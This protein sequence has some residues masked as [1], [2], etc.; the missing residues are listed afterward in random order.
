MKIPDYMNK[1]LSVAT[2]IELQALDAADKRMVKLEQNRM[3]IEW[4]GLQARRVA[5]IDDLEARLAMRSAMDATI[6]DATIT[7]PGS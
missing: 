4:I 2:W 7:T 3:V 1:Y 5:L 6:T